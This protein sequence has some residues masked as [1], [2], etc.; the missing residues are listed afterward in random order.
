MGYRNAEFV[1]FDIEEA[2]AMKKEISEYQFKCKQIIITVNRIKAGAWPLPYV[3]KGS[4]KDDHQF[5]HT[6]VSSHLVT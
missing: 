3:F 5:K 6:A 4:R 2:L 1:D